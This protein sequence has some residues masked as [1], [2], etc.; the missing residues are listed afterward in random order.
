MMSNVKKM[1]AFCIKEKMDILAHANAT[2]EI[3]AL[4]M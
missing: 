3:A 2:V 1:K 4:A